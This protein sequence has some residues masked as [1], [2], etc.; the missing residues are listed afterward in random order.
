MRDWELAAGVA[1]AMRDCL[2]LQRGDKA[3][4]AYDTGSVEVYEVI[5]EAA[6]V[7]GVSVEGVNIDSFNRPLMSLPGAIERRLTSGSYEA[8]FYVAGVRPGELNFRKRLVKLATG[9]GASHVHMPKANITILSKV[10]GCPSVAERL[11]RL[12][13][14]LQSSSTVTISSPSGTNLRVEV[15]LYR[16][17]IDNGVIERG[18]WGNWPPGEVFTTPAS[19][20]GTLDVDG[21]LGDYFSE[22]Y[23][24]LKGEP[25]KV[26][27]EAGAAVEIS[28]GAIAEE[29]HRYLSK[30]DCGLKA[31]ELGV[32]GNPRIT[33]PIGNM[34]HDEKMPGAHVALGDPLGEAT[35]APWSCPVHVD[36]LPLKSTVVAGSVT[37]VKDGRLQI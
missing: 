30:W 27:F 19:V 22:K 23:G 12:G 33:E 28:G 35:G 36:M 10:V 37:V 1:E 26:T 25:V 6:E 31:G 14:I 8:T 18:R 15:G 7:L 34:L 3:I 11:E 13:E 24:L 9:S 32:G 20:E 29:L 17:A 5:A 16:W 21:V 4:V 2:R